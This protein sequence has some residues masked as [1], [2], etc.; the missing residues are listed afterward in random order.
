MRQLRRYDAGGVAELTHQ[1]AEKRIQKLQQALHEHNIRYHVLD[2]PTISDAE[3]DQLMRELIQLE[4]QFPAFRNSASPTQRIGG[5]PLSHFQ[6][7]T[8]KEPMLSL[9]NA[10]QATDVQE[11]VDRVEKA[12][13]GEAVHY[14]CELKI[15]GLAVSLQYEDGRLVQGATRGDGETGEE[16]TQ[17][18]KTIK[19][20]P[21]QLLKPIQV[22]VRGEVF[23]PKKAFERLNQERE[24]KGEALLANPRNAAAGSMRQLDPKLAAERALDI[25][26][27]G[28]G[29]S[30]EFTPTTHTESLDYLTQLGFKVNQERKKVTSI[31]GILDYITY[32]QERRAELGYDID[33]IVIKVDQLAIREK[34]GFTAKSPRWAIAYKFPAEEVITTLLG[35]EL[36]V[37]RTGVVTPTALLAP[38]TLAGTVVKRASLHNQELIFER[39]IRIGDHVKVKKAGDI[40]PEV[41]ESLAHMRTGEEQVFQ[42]PPHCP[43][44]QQPLSQMEE[45]IAVRCTHPHCPAQVR[46]GLIHF[47]SRGAM[48]IEGLGEKVITQLFNEGLIQDVADLYTLQRTDLL[49]LERMGEKS[50]DNLLDSIEKSKG[51]SLERLLFGLGIRHVGAKGAKIL[52]QHFQTMDALMIASSEELL[53]LEEIGPKMAESLVTAFQQPALRTVIERLQKSGVNMDYLGPV[54]PKMTTS[55]T[56]KTVVL[57]GTLASMSRTEAQELLESLGAQVVSSVSKKT[58]FVI[59]GEKAGSKLAKAEKLDV[60][61]LDEEAFLRLVGEGK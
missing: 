1:E 47:V 30:G 17:N 14:V 41:V 40:I 28:L 44:C 60:A 33:G 34:M 15:D 38:V 29:S 54:I 21:L 57:T 36:N 27:Y 7:V 19:S 49:S 56:G 25:F 18:L 22:E 52:A 3:Y 55:F 4:E 20:I 32:W 8:H 51:N 26:V 12:A 2:Q 46:E 31:E 42:M 45:E 9:G 53:Q 43:E 24:S 50:V 39:D 37:G 48:N 58:D 35:I 23:M 10:F 61:V 59:A 13:Q 16:I 6:K 11:F 5:A